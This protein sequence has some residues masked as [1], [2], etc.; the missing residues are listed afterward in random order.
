MHPKGHKPHWKMLSVVMVN[1]VS[2]FSAR[3]KDCGFIGTVPLS[4]EVAFN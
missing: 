2:M 4:T 1:G 3:C